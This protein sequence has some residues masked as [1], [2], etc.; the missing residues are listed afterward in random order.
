MYLQ[1]ASGLDEIKRFGI[2]PLLTLCELFEDECLDL[3]PGSREYNLWIEIKGK[4]FMLKEVS[5]KVMA[6]N[7]V[8]RDAKKGVDPDKE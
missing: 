6:E 2:S 4:V 1:N 8:R 5:E 7:R 3:D